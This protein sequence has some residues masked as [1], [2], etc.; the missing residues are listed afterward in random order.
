MKP[1]ILL[2]IA[3]VLFVPVGHAA[4]TSWDIEVLLEED[5]TSGWTVTMAYNETVAKSD[6]FFLGTINTYNVTADGRPVKC[7]FAWDI[8]SSIVCDNLN[9][10]TIIYRFETIQVVQ[11]LQNMRVFK[12]RFSVLQPTESFRVT[13]KLPVG[14]PLAD[15]NQLRNT[16]LK[17]F[18]PDFGQQASDGRRIFVSWTLNKPIIGKTIDVAVVYEQLEQVQINIF[19]GIIVALVVA[20]LAV[21]YFLFKRRLVKDLLPVLTDAERKVVEIILRE[22]GSVDQRQIVKETDFS[23]A[24]V[25]RVISNLVHRG[26]IEKEIKGR[27]NIIR[28]KKAIK[29]EKIAKSGIAKKEAEK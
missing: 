5:K 19:I 26:I 13:V 14:S 21:L 3:L 24:K 11:T 6:Y 20:F 1:W 23:K 4:L 25:S 16:E 2:F 8:G 12:Y 18:E 28:L 29:P 9:A 22:K 27:K 7:S 17:P 15:P 10:K